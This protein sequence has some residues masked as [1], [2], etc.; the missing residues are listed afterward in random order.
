MVGLEIAVPVVAVD[1]VGAHQP[2]EVTTSIQSELPQALRRC[3]T[4][5]CFQPVL[6]APKSHMDLAAIA[7]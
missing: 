1:S 3:N 2:V 5:L 4:D 6:L 7:A